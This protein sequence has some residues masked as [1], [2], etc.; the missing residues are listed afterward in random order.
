[1]AKPTLLYHSLLTAALAASGTAA[2]NFV[3]A[4]LTD[5]RP[6]TWWKPAAMPATLTMDCGSAQAADY[7]LVHGHDLATQ[8]ATL[9]IRASTD[10]FA[11]SD[12]LVATKTPT[13]DAPFLLLFASA[14]YRYWRVRITGATAPSL[15]IVALGRRLEMP[16]WLP[17]G[18]DPLG[19]KVDSQFNRNAN[20]QPLGRVIDFEEWSETLSFQRIPWAWMRDTW[21]AVWETHVRSAP[22]V[23]AWESDLYPAELRLVTA[24]PKFSARHYAGGTCDLEFDVTGVVA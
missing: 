13:T 7:A 23:L 4:N 8:G 12:V 2:G 15:A 17:Q 1:M 19:R 18:F 24:G 20:G 16:I 22:F 21:Q 6:Y 11:V 3:A 14:S 9:E 10:N 5:W